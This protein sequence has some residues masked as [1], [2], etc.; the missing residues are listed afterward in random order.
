LANKTCKNCIYLYRAQNC[1]GT[2][3]CTNKHNEPGRLF[4]LKEDITCRNFSAPF[5]SQRPKIRQPADPNTR[6][7]PLTKGRFAIVD[8]ADY[9]WLNQYKWC[10]SASRNRFFARSAVKGKGIWMHRLIM[11]PPA[12]MVVDHI[13]GNSLNNKRENLRI[14]TAR[15]NSYNRK[16]YGTASKYK[17]VH[18]NKST[19]RWV[20][21]IKHYGVSIFLGS[22]NSEINAAK[23]YDKKA[24][25][26][27]GEFSYLNFPD[28]K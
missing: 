15:Q 28:D 5:V 1:P 4:I 11:N 16:G 19:K 2:F 22:F 17:G 13:D 20:A 12:G 9:D 26:L 18:W 25:E 7:I 27:F 10:A 6:F 3:I 24:K 14:C 21:V 23:A 8:A